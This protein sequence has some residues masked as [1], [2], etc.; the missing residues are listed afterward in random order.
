MSVLIG[1]RVRVRLENPG[2]FAGRRPGGEGLA[3]V[4]RRLALAYGSAATLQI[5]SEGGQT[6]A[7]VEL[8]LARSEAA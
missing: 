8:P 4:E 2:A 1:D 7:V 3:M 5:G 6:V